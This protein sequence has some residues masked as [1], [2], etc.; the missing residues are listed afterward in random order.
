MTNNQV[1]NMLSV[2]ES[3]FYY[4]ADGSNDRENVSF[5][6]C[7]EMHDAINELLKKWH[8]ITGE[9]LR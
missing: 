1:L 4:R 8:R 2:L 5:Q 6:E 3:E 7:Q 9:V